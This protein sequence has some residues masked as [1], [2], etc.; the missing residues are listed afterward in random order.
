MSGL[1]LDTA[2]L[3]ALKEKDYDGFI[4]KL[5]DTLMEHLSDALVDSIDPEEKIAAIQVILEHYEKTE[6]YE[7]CQELYDL[8]KKIKEANA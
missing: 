7:R 1:Y 8:Q 6:R 2:E 3:L 5:Y 4:D